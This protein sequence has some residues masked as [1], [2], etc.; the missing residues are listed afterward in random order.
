MST[1][2]NKDGTL[3]SKAFE[4]L[5]KDVIMS[6]MDKGNKPYNFANFA[7]LVIKDNIDYGILWGSRGLGKSTQVAAYVL[8]K[9][10]EKGGEF[11]YIRRYK[12]EIAP[13]MVTGW[14]GNLDISKLT[15][16]VWDSIH[17]YNKI[18]YFAKHDKTG[19]IKTKKQIGWYEAL[20]VAG[21]NK[22]LQFPFVNDIVM[23]EMVPED[24]PWLNREPS[25]LES[26]ISTI[27]RDRKDIT[28]W[29]IGNTTTKLCPYIKDWGLDRM[30]KMKP[31][32][33]DRYDKHVS[34]RDEAGLHETVVTYM[35]DNCKGL[36]LFGRVMAGEGSNQIV[37]NSF[38]TFSQ[39]TVKADF[40]DEC[41]ILY[42]MY[43][44]HQ[45]LAFKMEFIRASATDYF[46]YVKPAK[47][48]LK[49]EDLQDDRVLTDVVD[50]NPLHTGIS[51]VS[52]KEKRVFG[53]F[54]LNKVFYS[55]NE[56]GTD[57]KQCWQ[58]LLRR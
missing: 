21:N 27:V 46:W 1:I 23:E 3:D 44:F 37:S 20:N 2:F 51:P 18:I 38:T 29:M 22:S 48:G 19:K 57:F 35:V 53:Y 6:P 42:H 56:T 49:I 10:Y 55:D 52:N 54:S 7:N 30:P 11:F 47:N 32:Q 58:A 34:V 40:I 28:T 25:R 14:V 50:F 39:P 9:I 24:K 8:R 15:D 26:F 5:L 17:A 36:G 41:D 13:I 4:A 12:E 43:L 16:G 33:V 31:G 45:N